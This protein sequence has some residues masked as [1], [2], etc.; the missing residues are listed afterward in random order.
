MAVKLKM[1]LEMIFIESI[2][3]ELDQKRELSTD[4]GEVNS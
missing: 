4:G 3:L 2:R 1:K